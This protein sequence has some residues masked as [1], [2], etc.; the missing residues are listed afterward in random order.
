MRIRG[1]TAGFAVAALVCVPATL[2]TVA[3]TAHALSAHPLW[4]ANSNRLTEG[5]LPGSEAPF[6]A[7]GEMVLTSPG[8]IK[9]DCYVEEEGRVFNEGGRGLGEI[10]NFNS[11]DCA[12]PKFPGECAGPLKPG[13]E[14]EQCPA[15][16]FLTAEMPI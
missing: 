13:L 1:R 15:V 14:P 4:H 6:V 11:W 8:G 16:S 12:Q 7:R 9:I 10:T 2:G 3:T 5:R